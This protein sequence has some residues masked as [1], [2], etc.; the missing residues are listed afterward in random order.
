[1][2]R[3]VIFLVCLII[4]TMVFGQNETKQINVDVEEVQVT[5]PT[6]AGVLNADELFNV[7][8][9]LAIFIFQSF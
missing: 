9:S 4:S 8:N 5:P 3:N 2:K 7:G 1:M 6:F